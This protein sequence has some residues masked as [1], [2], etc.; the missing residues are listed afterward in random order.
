MTRT[1]V[2]GRR[3]VTL[4]ELLIVIAIM[5][6]LLALAAAL[7]PSI[8]S[9]DQTQKGAAE[10]QATCRIAQGYAATTGRPHGVG[11]IVNGG[12]FCTELQ[13][14]EAPDVLVP[15]PKVLVATAT[16]PTGVNGPRVELFYE[17]YN[18]SETS[19][20]PRDAGASPAVI[21]P[22]GTIKTRHCYIRGLT[23]EQ[24]TQVVDRATLS[25]PAVGV[26]SRIRSTIGAVPGQP[27]EVILEVYPDAFMGATTS[28][29]S[30]HF[31]IY[32][33]PVPMLAEPTVP[34]PKDIAVD[35]EV[36][37]PPL[38]TPGTNYE[39]MFAPNGQPL[40]TRNMATNTNGYFL[41]RDTSK[42]NGSLRVIGPALGAAFRQGGEMQ[43]VGVRAG[44]FVGVAPAMP[45]D[46]S[47]NYS[48]QYPD[49]FSL[50]REQLNR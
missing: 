49:L 1:L 33:V 36:S 11:L 39:I 26:W 48:A 15:D 34:L 20:D 12:Y 40:G 18:G 28:Y 6:A 9:S 50:A 46:D 13:Y 10:L 41:V 24:R 3:A 42:F 25:L 30:Y 23:A 29:R 44:G 8:A 5:T 19:I 31:G 35:L 16:N 4:I 17:V 27:D 45:A 2:R 7:A 21:P 38:P 37:S 47:G 43:I 22:R 32:G 14:L